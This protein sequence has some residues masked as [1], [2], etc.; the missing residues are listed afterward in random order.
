M[1]D[2]NAPRGPKRRKSPSLRRGALILFALF[3][4]VCKPVTAAY[5][6]PP[7]HSFLST[8]QSAGALSCRTS[9]LLLSPVH[10]RTTNYSYRRRRDEPIRLFSKKN[11]ESHH[12]SPDFIPDV[13][14][15][16]ADK[17]ILALMTAVVCCSFGALLSVSGPGA[18]RYFLAGGICAATSHAVATPIDVVKVC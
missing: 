17:A 5:S 16:A 8:S 1:S 4:Y 10:P 12:L 3:A 18:W 2:G 7:A 9:S 6:S 14:I 15:S 11:C 13:T